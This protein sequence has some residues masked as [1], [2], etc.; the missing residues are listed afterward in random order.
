MAGRKRR[1]EEPGAPVK[2][3]TGEHLDLG[4]LAKVSRA[5]VAE[6][7]LREAVERAYLH[8]IAVVAE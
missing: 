5:D 1:T 3:L 2:H 8:K 7:I 6:S 4:T